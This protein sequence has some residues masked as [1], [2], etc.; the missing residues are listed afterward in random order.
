LELGFHPAIP[1]PAQSRCTGGFSPLIQSRMRFLR[2][3][4]G[5][6]LHAIGSPG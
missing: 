3:A 2:I 1:R 6:L 5:R 4:S